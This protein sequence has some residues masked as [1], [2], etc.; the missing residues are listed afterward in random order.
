MPVRVSIENGS[1]EPGDPITSSSLA[2]VGMKA[3]VPGRI[4]GTALSSYDGSGV[5]E[6]IVLVGSS[7]YNPPA[8]NLIQGQSNFETINILGNA[9]IASLNVSGATTLTQLTVTGSATIEG[10]LKVTGSLYVGSLFVGG[11]LVSRSPTPLINKSESLTGVSGVQ[12]SL[13]GTDTAGTIVVSLGSHISPGGEL[14]EITFDQPYFSTPKIVISGNNKKSAKLGAYL[15]RTN[16]G[17]K[18]ISDDPLEANTTYEFDYI[19]VG[20]NI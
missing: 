19:V 5:G 16:N 17:F 11:H 6:V 12:V 10:S 18:L 13:N 3:T 20:I 8:V 2:G 14:V 15:I 4:I 7:F 9:Q 1:I